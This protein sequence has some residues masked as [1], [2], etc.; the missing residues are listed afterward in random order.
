MDGMAD[1]AVE[2]VGLRHPNRVQPGND[3]GV[4]ARTFPATMT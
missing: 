3:E 1:M 2:A 4:E